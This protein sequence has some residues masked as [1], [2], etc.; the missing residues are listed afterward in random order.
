[1]SKQSS[2]HGSHLKPV[3]IHDTT[4][5]GVPI[6]VMGYEVRPAAFSAASYTVGKC[7]VHRDY[8]RPG[9]TYHRD[10]L[11]RWTV[12]DA[13]TGAS[14]VDGIKSADLAIMQAAIK[15]VAVDEQRYHARR[16]AV[17]REQHES[18]VATKAA[19]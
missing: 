12:T 3:R 9:S 5:P 2:L 6:Y 1:M 8:Q 19:P 15:L 4:S 16:L 18:Y 11:R 7:Y 14:I 10:I 17:M 13:L